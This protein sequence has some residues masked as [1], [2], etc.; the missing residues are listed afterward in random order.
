ME[1]S[2]Y[3]AVRKKHE[4]K[5]KK[6]P[7]VGKIALTRTGLEEAGSAVK[8]SAPTGA[9]GPSIPQDLTL[10]EQRPQTT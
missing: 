6:K 4:A 9:P 10:P 2:K 1:K 5:N 3:N 7:S 8:L